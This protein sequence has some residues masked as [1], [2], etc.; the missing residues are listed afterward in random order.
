MEGIPRHEFEQ[1]QLGD[2]A[3]Y[4]KDVQPDDLER[5]LRQ[6]KSQ[7]VAGAQLWEFL[8]RKNVGD[9]DSLRGDLLSL[10]SDTGK[11]DRDGAS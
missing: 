1:R 4:L 11:W 6:T 10:N 2:V 9:A 7:D 8:I 3:A 5:K